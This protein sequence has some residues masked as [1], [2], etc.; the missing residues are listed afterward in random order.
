[1]VFYLDND[2]DMNHM[3]VRNFTVLPKTWVW[4]AQSRLLELLQSANREIIPQAI[5]T[6][7][8]LSRTS[9]ALSSLMLLELE[10][11]FLF[12]PIISHYKSL[13]QLIITITDCL[14]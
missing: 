7:N 2:I 5:T 1:M 10:L 9:A 6:S 4:A 13:N 14:L 12:T 11:D 3:Y 8:S